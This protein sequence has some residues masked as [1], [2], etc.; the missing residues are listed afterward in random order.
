MSK[1]YTEEQVKQMIDKSRETGL[2]A[3]YIILTTPSTIELPTDKEI[4]D[5]SNKLGY[6]SRSVGIIHN[7]F[8]VGAK[9][10]RDKVG[11][12]GKVERVIG[13]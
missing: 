8:Q 5:A 12:L 4:E 11:E 6:G 3:E 1:L 13:E 9:W 7:A 2:T 10:M